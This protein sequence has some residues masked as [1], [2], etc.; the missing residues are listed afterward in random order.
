MSEISGRL[1]ELADQNG[2]SIREF[3][4]K[5]GVSNGYI[6]NIRS[7]IQPAVLRR[8]VEQFSAVS[9]EWI[10]LGTAKMYASAA[11]ETPAIS[12]YRDKYI[13]ALEKITSLQS[14]NAEL[15]AENAELKKALSA[16][17][18]ILTAVSEKVSGERKKAA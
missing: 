13:A 18:E 12:D 7:S 14:E 4:R 1:K 2:L 16:T 11:T 15:I 10:M 5:I 3:E 6:K 9:V 8:V 17:P